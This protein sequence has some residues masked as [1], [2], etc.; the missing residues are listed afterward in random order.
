MNA[1]EQEPDNSSKRSAAERAKKYRRRTGS[2]N[3][4]RER[5]KSDMD[6]SRLG[7]LSNS[8]L[9]NSSSSIILPIKAIKTKR[10]NSHANHSISKSGSISILDIINSPKKAN[11]IDLIENDVNSNNQSSSLRDA[12]PLK[13]VNQSLN[14]TKLTE[15]I[16]RSST[17]P[18]INPSIEPSPIAQAPGLVLTLEEPLD[19]I[20]LPKDVNEDKKSEMNQNEP[21]KQENSPTKKKKH[22]IR[23]RKRQGGSKSKNAQNSNPETAKD[24]E[25]HSTRS[26]SSKKLSDNAVVA[27]THKLSKSKSK[28]DSKGSSNSL[29]QILGLEKENNDQNAEEEKPKPECLIKPPPGIDNDIDELVDTFLPTAD[30]S[31]A[32]EMG[33]DLSI[34]R[35][36]F[37]SITKPVLNWYPFQLP[38]I[39]EP[40]DYDLEI[41]GHNKYDFIHM[42]HEIKHP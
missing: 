12:P 13:P 27:S 33:F 34:R 42:I 28:K 22:V 7:N 39:P 17:T 4:I 25:K 3:K 18:L 15:N 32:V 29:L 24:Q 6:L 16:T 11:K 8:E 30:K 38:N 31:A 41:Q 35:F 5:S 23:K 36:E 2:S 9:A 19:L 10:K 37:N 21:I 26:K 40:D 1:N 14:D 20:I